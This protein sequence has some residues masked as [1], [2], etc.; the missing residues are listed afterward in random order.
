M[1][2][3]ELVKGL[4]GRQAGYAQAAIW[5]T[6]AWQAHVSDGMCCSM[7]PA[8]SVLGRRLA[9]SL[10]AL[11]LM[12]A[13]ESGTH[14]NMNSTLP[15]S[16]VLSGRDTFPGSCFCPVLGPSSAAAALPSSP[17]SPLLLGSSLGAAFDCFSLRLEPALGASAAAAVSGPSPSLSEAAVACFFAA[18]PAGCRCFFFAGLRVLLAACSGSSFDCLVVGMVA[19]GF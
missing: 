9:C 6:T 10:S 17:L 8:T 19:T 7:V 2:G 12:F 13:Q 15:C 5:V 18:L 14:L 1:C 3:L 4:N 16:T 11:R